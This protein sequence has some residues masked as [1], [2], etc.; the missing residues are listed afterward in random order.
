MQDPEERGKEL[1]VRCYQE[2]DGFLAKDKIAEW[3]GGQYVCSRCFDGVDG[4]ESFLGSGPINKIALRY[5][6]DYFDFAGLRLDNAFRC[7]RR[8]RGGSSW[9]KLKSAGAY[10]PSF[11]SRLKRNKS[12]VSSRSLADAFGIAILSANM[13]ARVR[14]HHL[15]PGVRWLMRHRRRPCG[16]LLSSTVKHRSSCGRYYHAHVAEPIRPEHHD[17]HPDAASSCAICFDDGSR[18]R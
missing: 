13:G 17:R 5:Y 12:I 9:L 8:L 1:A 2:D 11:I 10:V 3:L 16:H 14:T 15:L 7:V 18:P 6:M 4:V